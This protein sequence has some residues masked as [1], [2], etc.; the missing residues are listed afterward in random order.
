MCFGTPRTP[1]ISVAPPP[2]PLPL[3]PPPPQAPPAPQQAPQTLTTDKKR[4]GVKLRRSR[5]E[6]SGAVARGTNQLRIPLNTGT[7]KSGGMN[8]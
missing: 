3:P 7:S 6:Q 2:P 5:A 1:E 4:P 8:F